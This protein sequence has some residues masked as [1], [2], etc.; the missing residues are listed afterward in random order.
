MNN[1]EKLGAAVLFGW[2]IGNA[3]LISEQLYW[4]SFWSFISS[5]V[6]AGLFSCFGETQ[7][8]DK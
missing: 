6:I 4:S 5:L 7:R 8:S 3:Y 2:A 1:Y